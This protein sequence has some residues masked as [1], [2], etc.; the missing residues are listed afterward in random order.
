MTSCE[1]SRHRVHSAEDEYTP[2]PP[3]QCL[4]AY[5]AGKQGSQP[6]SG[7]LSALWLALAIAAWGAVHSVLAS[8]PIKDYVRRWFGENAGQIYRLAYNAFSVLSFAPILLLVRLL[9]DR[10]L[11][12][13]RLPWLLLFLA[14]E[15]LAAAGLLVAVLQTDALGL[16]GLRQL[17]GGEERSQLTT[18]GVYRYVRH[19]MYLF[20]LLILW[21]TPF[22]TLNLL[23]T[24]AALSFYVWLGAYFEEKKLA[25]EYGAAYREYKAHTP[26]LLPFRLRDSS[27]PA[28]KK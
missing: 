28:E 2:G 8:R 7:F 19:P 16:I 4:A 24:Y 10:V 5:P 12:V 22:M 6:V 27:V 21:L 1:F 11:Y 14:G 23:I 13:V 15:V 17:A 25:R 3:G 9:P 20:G 18:H 26:M